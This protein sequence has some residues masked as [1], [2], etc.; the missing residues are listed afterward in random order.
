MTAKISVLGDIRRYKG[1]IVSIGTKTSG[2]NNIY[3]IQEVYFN[4]GISIL[5]IKK[6]ELIPLSIP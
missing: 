6:I 2:N 1:Q 5:N 3:K 4:S